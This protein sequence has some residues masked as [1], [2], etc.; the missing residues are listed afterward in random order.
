[1]LWQSPKDMVS[2]KDSRERISLPCLL[3]LWLGWSNSERVIMMVCLSSV[4]EW[5]LLAPARPTS[6]YKDPSVLPLLWVSCLSKGMWKRTVWTYEAPMASVGLFILFLEL[7]WIYTAVR[8]RYPDLNPDHSCSFVTSLQH[9]NTL[10]KE[11]WYDI[12]I[13]RYDLT[14]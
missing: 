10:S 13:V 12:G 8:A 11:G 4:F 7:G 5:R 1:M 9:T 14:D 6:S 3:G 2:G